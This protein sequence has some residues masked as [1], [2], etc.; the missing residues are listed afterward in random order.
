MGDGHGLGGR[1]DEEEGGAEIGE[2][3]FPNRGL[4]FQAGAG[5]GHGGGRHGLDL[6]VAERRG[7]VAAHG[8][9]GRRR[10]ELRPHLGEGRRAGAVRHHRRQAAVGED[11]PAPGVLAGHSA[12]LVAL[13]ADGSGDRRPGAGGRRQTVPH[14]GGG[15]ATCSPSFDWETRC[16]LAESQTNISENR[17]PRSLTGA[18]T[19]MSFN[20]SMSAPS[21][22]TAKKATWWWASSSLTRRAASSVSSVGA[23]SVIMKIQGR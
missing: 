12:P 11:A 14:P 8:G 10:G 9:E 23:P 16:M 20:L 13:A 2:R 19:L 18:R 17:R 5:G 4:G 6:R 7:S 21:T 1:E 3:H 22:P 15:R